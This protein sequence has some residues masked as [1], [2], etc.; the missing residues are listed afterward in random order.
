LPPKPLPLKIPSLPSSLKFS[1]PTHLTNLLTDQP[2]KQENTK[3][4]PR[5]YY[6]SRFYNNHPNYS[7]SL[8]FFRPNNKLRK[9]LQF[10]TDRKKFSLIK[11]FA[12][13]H[14]IRVYYHIVIWLAIIGSTIVGALD[15]PQVRHEYLKSGSGSSLIYWKFNLCFSIIL[16]FEFLFLIIANGFLFAPKAY[17]RGFWNRIDLLVLVLQVIDVILTYKVMTSSSR[18]F[19]ILVSLRALRLATRTKTLKRTLYSIFIAGFVKLMTVILILLAFI[20]PFA[21]LG[22]AM[23]GGKMQ[24]CNLDHESIIYMEDCIGSFLKDDGILMPKVWSNPYMYSFD[25]L[26]SSLILLI[27]LASR[28]KWIDVMKNTMNI[29]GERM[30]PRD[31]VSWWY[32]LYFVVYFL[33]V[34]LIGIS[35]FIAV[36]INNHREFT[37]IAEI[38][39]DEKNWIDL[40]KQLNQ[41]KPS[42]KMVNYPS[43]LG[44]K[45]W[46][47]KI[48]TDKRSWWNR[49]IT[50]S[51]F[52]I[53]ILVMAGYYQM[54]E[55]WR[56]IR[57]W[58][59][60]GCLCLSAINEAIQLYGRGSDVY[61][62]NP[63]NTIFLIINIFAI[64]LQMSLSTI[65]LANVKDTL[66]S[67][68][69]SDYDKYGLTVIFFKKLGFCLSLV[70][71]MKLIV[72]L[73][74]LLQLIYILKA[75]LKDILE[76]AYVWFIIFVIFAIAMNQG[77]GGL[78]WGTNMS[79]HVNANNYLAIFLML[80]RISTGEGWNDI[81][82]DFKV[83]APNCVI[84]ENYLESDCGDPWL[85]TIL[86]ISFHTISVY[87]FSSMFVV[88][89]L[90]TFSYCYEI[91]ASFSFVSRQDLREFKRNWSQ[92]DPLGLGYVQ[93]PDLVK[94]LKGLETPFKIR[95]FPMKF[96]PIHMCNEY[97]RKYKEKFG[98]V[99]WKRGTP[100]SEIDPEVLKDYC[101]WLN[102][103]LDLLKTSK[104][105]QRKDKFNLIY[106]ECCQFILHSKGKGLEFNKFLLLIAQYK[107]IDP[108]NCFLLSELIPYQQH[109]EKIQNIYNKQK[110]MG[111]FTNYM[112]RWRA[113]R[114]QIYLPKITLGTADYQSDDSDPEYEANGRLLTPVRR[115]A[116]NLKLSIPK[117][118]Q[119]YGYLSSPN[120]SSPE[121][122]PIS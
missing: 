2:K 120:S 57:L 43:D 46:C 109:Q 121:Y 59:I 107:I 70:V 113:R 38:T 87:I 103:Q 17:L 74:P 62:A 7:R 85:A 25:S 48:V 110:I 78:K 5:D 108:M 39:E 67:I 29:V 122:S 6:R 42:K 52:S 90:D 93:K 31:E 75:S 44:L 114:I 18:L 23:F 21:V 102:K 63:I 69:L 54:S 106:I 16:T 105:K 56:L 77:F 12:K 101:K 22:K 72:K 92:V 98:Y 96:N 115:I 118:T 84:N 50:L 32:C 80:F 61:L 94:L 24:M 9:F 95:F 10:L 34:Q 66:Q 104:L 37:G 19:H 119:S 91:F 81:M 41:V 35:T 11:N 47:F 30:Q 14:D 76:L 97:N 117:P 68:N 51:Y 45:R 27:E 111:L 8:F 73:D 82:Y 49:M 64:L 20:V 36:I 15:S 65:N 60:I 3:F 1:L 4:T 89:L 79:Y 33:G 100:P 40:K 71:S 13:L 28:E 86:F 116:P 83:Q 99:G 88:F 58:L 53:F 26:G 112:K 55:T